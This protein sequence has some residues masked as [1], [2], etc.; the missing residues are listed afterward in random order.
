M[1]LTS[2]HA[3]FAEYFCCLWYIRTVIYHRGD[4]TRE[5]V[6]RESTRKRDVP[7]VRILRPRSRSELKL[8]GVIVGRFEGYISRE[9]FCCVSS[10]IMKPF[11]NVRWSSLI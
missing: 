5:M 11:H 2:L 6:S 3:S 7:S 9:V 10:D 1:A 8:L 4:S